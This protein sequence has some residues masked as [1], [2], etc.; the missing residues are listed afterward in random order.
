M[1]SINFPKKRFVRTHPSVI[2]FE[3]SVATSLLPHII[4]MKMGIHLSPR[5][6][7]LKKEGFYKPFVVLVLR[8]RKIE[9][10]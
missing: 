7:F 6:Y 9:K 4:P 3:E 8:C 2:A 1:Q 5:N 10:D